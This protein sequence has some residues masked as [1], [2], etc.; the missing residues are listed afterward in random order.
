MGNTID[1]TMIANAIIALVA[2]IITTFIIPWLRSK[3]TE[4]QRKDILAW[5]SVAV[6]AA[7]QIYKGP[8]KGEQ[9]KRYVLNYLN[10]RGYTIDDVSVELAIEAAV[11]EIT[12]REAL[13][14]A[15]SDDE[16]EEGGDDE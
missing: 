3:T 9:K 1:L 7:E 4:N 2:A 8:G 16:N 5:V 13:I 11:K 6:K 14:Y 15:E 12:E 10:S